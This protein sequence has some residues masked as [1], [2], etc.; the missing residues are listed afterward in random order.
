M[1]HK[2]VEKIQFY[3]ID[4]LIGDILSFLDK[5][6]HNFYT[7]SI[8]WDLRVIEM[9]YKRQVDEKL[10]NIFLQKTKSLLESAKCN[11]KII[12]PE[13]FCWSHF[14][15]K[16]QYNLILILMLLMRSVL[17]EENPFINIFLKDDI[18]I[19]DLKNCEDNILKRNSYTNIALKYLSQDNLINIVNNSVSYKIQK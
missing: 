17:I 16:N 12:F 15:E 4:A 5:I 13:D 9:I 1:E 6:G 11:C 19:L 2:T 7:Q 3:P 14:S 18:L 8:E 10:I